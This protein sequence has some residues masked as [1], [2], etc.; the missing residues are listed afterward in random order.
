[1]KTSLENASVDNP[2]NTWLT[3]RVEKSLHQLLEKSGRYIPEEENY[4][5]CY[6][7]FRVSKQENKKIFFKC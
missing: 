2:V 6:V 1:M 5:S 4:N 7:Y 3:S